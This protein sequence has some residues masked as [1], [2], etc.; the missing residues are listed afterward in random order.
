[1]ERFRLTADQAFTRLVRVSQNTNRQLIDV[2]ERLAVT[3][4]VRTLSATPGQ[5]EQ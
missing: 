5:R 4:H 2:V 3:G 1:M